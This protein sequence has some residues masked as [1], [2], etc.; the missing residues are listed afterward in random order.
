ML[1]FQIV[2][3]AIL[4]CCFAFIS[5]DRTQQIMTPVTDAGDTA[6][7]AGDTAADDTAVDDTTAGD[8]GAGDAAADTTAGTGDTAADDTG[9]AGDAAAGNTDAGAQ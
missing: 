7:S 4:V 1:K 8:T 3:I 6:A 9:G 2:L 5:C